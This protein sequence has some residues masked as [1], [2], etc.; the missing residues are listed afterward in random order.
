MAKRT[1][2]EVRADLAAAVEAHE[3]ERQDFAK[4][5]ALG[6]WGKGDRV[7]VFKGRKVKKGTEGVVIWEGYGQYGARLG[8]KDD[9]E[10]VHWTARSNCRLT[11]EAIAALCEEA[12]GDWVGMLERARAKAAAEVDARRASTPPKGGKVRT[13]SGREGSIFWK[14][15]DGS[16]LGVRWGKG[17]EDVEWCNHDQVEAI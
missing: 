8:L 1:E 4:R 2:V 9:A 3:A 7:V 10:V 15:D 17:R 16:R 5:D 6:D 13:V 12:G 11:D 14:S